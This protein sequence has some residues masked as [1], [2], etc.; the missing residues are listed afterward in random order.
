VSGLG[1]NMVVDG[2]RRSRLDRAPDDG[3]SFMVAV[4]AFARSA[5]MMALGPFAGIVADRVLPDWVA[6]GPVARFLGLITQ[7]SLV[8]IQPPQP[9]KTVGQSKMTNPPLAF[10]GAAW[11]DSWPRRE[12]G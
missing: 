3:S 8:Q 6:F 4:A 7:R 1:S 10:L 12:A 5:P 9:N 2:S 11:P